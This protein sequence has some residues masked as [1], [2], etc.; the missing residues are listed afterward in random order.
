MPLGVL[1][2]CRGRVLVCN[3]VLALMKINRCSKRRFPIRLVMSTKQKNRAHALLRYLLRSVLWLTLTNRVIVLLCF[4]G[5]HLPNTWL[6]AEIIDNHELRG[7]T[8]VAAST[9]DQNC[10]ATKRNLWDHTLTHT[11][12]YV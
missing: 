1:Y 8:I 9:E 2:C 4:C 11:H 3:I 10:N 6:L 7:V 12:M 5:G